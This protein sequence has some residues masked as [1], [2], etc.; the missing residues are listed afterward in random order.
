LPGF[1]ADVFFTAP[2]FLVSDSAG[3]AAVSRGEA[4]SFVVGAAGSEAAALDVFLVAVRSTRAAD[5][6]ADSLPELR[7]SA[8]ALLLFPEL[9]AR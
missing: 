5:L 1:I 7:K 9:A 2:G 4:P 6:E 3:V 8:S